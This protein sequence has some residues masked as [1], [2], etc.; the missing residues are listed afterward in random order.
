MASD[1]YTFAFKEEGAG[2]AVTPPQARS[3]FP[4]MPD[5]TRI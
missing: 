5:L 3:G 2:A 1:G 4:D